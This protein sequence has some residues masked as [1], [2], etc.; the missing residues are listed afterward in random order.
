VEKLV[1]AGIL[2]KRAGPSNPKVFVAREILRLLDEPLTETP[3][4][5]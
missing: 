4:T 3:T 2:K 5:R 1:E